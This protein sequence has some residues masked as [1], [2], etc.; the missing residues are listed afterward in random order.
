MTIELVIC[1]ICIVTCILVILYGN[2]LYKQ[3]EELKND[4]KEL[5]HML[6]DRTVHITHHIRD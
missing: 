4:I 5:R 3:N 1:V 2:D 6:K